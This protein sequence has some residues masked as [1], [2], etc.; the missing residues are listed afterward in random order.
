MNYT[1][2]KGKEGA[3]NKN[4]FRA[5]FR[6]GF[7]LT[8]VLTVVVIVGILT[9]IALPKYMR[10]VERARAT[11]AMSVTKALNDSISAYY[12]DKEECPERFSQLVVSLP[13]LYAGNTSSVSTTNFRFSLGSAPD[14]VAGTSC[15]GVLA[16]RI[17]G[18]GYNY[19]IWNPYT[20]GTTGKAL[21]LQCNGSDEKNIAICESLGLYREP[22]PEEEPE[23]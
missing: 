20:R 6:S 14:N 16:E 21:A 13:N 3:L 8:E 9:S 1:N 22:D 7:T 15:K 11:E 5:S 19:T 12:A 17:N 2:T 4:F 10:S 23:E 18:G